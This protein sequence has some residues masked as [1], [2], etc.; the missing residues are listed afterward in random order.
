MFRFLFLTK[1]E[2]TGSLDEAFRRT[3]Y[4]L[5]H[6]SDAEAAALKP[7]RIQV[8]RVKS[9]DTVESLASRMP[10]PDYKVERFRVLNGLVDNARLEPG[11][12]VKTIVEGDV[13]KDII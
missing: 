13:S 6:L 1:P 10:F 9:G 2:Q 11:T 5:R 3:T 4:S 12:L 8:V 7:Y